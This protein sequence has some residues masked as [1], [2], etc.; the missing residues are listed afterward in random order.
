[1]QKK[2]KK[3]EII[4]V[5]DCSKDN[6]ANIAFKYKKENVKLINNKTNIGKGYSVKKGILHAKHALVL[7]SDSDLATP[8]QEL[9]KFLDYMKEG[10]DIVIASRRMK[11]SNVVTTQPFFRQLL[12][13]T[14]PLLVNI[15]ALPDFKD[16]QCGF[17]LFKTSLA[18]K[19]VKLQTFERFS[20]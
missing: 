1:M 19:I 12:G 5:N 8:I 4:I 13:K 10:F 18:K 15:I 17:K 16:T 7:F 14:F 9:D 20:F 11:E 2:F 3:Y 6:T